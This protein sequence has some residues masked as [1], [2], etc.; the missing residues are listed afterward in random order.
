LRQA[1]CLRLI[2]VPWTGMDTFPFHEM[3][4]FTIPLCNSH[5][6]S[7]YVAEHVLGLLFSLLKKLPFHDRLMREGNW[8]RSPE[9]GVT[10]ASSLISGKTVGF[11][12]YGAIGQ[13]IGRFLMPFEC[14]IH[15]LER[16]RSKDHCDEITKYFLTD[17]FHDFLAE[18]DIVVISVPLTESTRNLFDEKAFSHMKTISFL[19]NASRSEIVGE[20]ALF[21]ALSHGVIAGYASDVWWNSPQRGLGIAKVSNFFDFE[22]FNNVVFSPHRAGFAENGF[23]H[24]DDAIDNIARLY[25]NEPLRNIVN[26]EDE[27]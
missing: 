2:Q 9:Y 4:G 6:N 17:Q 7:L 14:K 5:S 1:K 12:G 11:V 26:I 19:I 24:L 25:H 21:H 3:K 18:T 22:R 15:V 13:K 20:A 10:L 16:D 23:P 8:N 27:F